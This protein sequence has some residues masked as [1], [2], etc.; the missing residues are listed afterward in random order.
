MPS[1][2]WVLKTHEYK[3]G[4]LLTADLAEVIG[5]ADE[6]AANLRKLVVS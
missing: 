6:M 5:P 3:D 4:D 1:L 2:P